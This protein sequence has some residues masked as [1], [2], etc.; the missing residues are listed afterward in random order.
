MVKDKKT[1]GIVDHLRNGMPPV[2]IDNSLRQAIIN[3]T[4]EDYKRMRQEMSR[5]S[6]R[7]GMIDYHWGLKENDE[8]PEGYK[9]KLATFT[10]EQ[11]KMFLGGNWKTEELNKDGTLNWDIK[12]TNTERGNNMQE[13]KINKVT[14]G[15]VVDIGCLKFVFNTVKQLTEAVNLYYTDIE[16]AKK[17]YWPEGK[18]QGEGEPVGAGRDVCK[19]ELREIV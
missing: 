16:K 1:T 10:D 14:N 8:I 5:G 18:T 12:E 7:Q 2:T 3:Q 17:K 13:L 6:Y 4:G 15:F 9:R 19:Q 11:K